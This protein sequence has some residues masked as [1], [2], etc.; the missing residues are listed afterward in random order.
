MTGSSAMM[1][2]LI[3]KKSAVYHAFD[4]RSRKFS[5]STFARY[6]WISSVSPR[7]RLFSIITSVPPMRS[8]LF[9]AM[10]RIAEKTF[11]PFACTS[12]SLVMSFLM[13][14]RILSDFG[15]VAR[16]EGLRKAAS[17]ALM[18]L[19]ILRRLLSISAFFCTR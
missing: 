19:V 5:L 9:C 13:L 16:F 17:S 2:S 15:R 18:G 11:P 6:S 14:S 1:K 7:L 3:V 8:V 12:S 10:L 4:S